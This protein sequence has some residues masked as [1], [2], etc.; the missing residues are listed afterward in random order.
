VETPKPAPVETG[1]TVVQLA[2][3][4]DEHAATVMAQK[5]QIKYQSILGSAHLHPVRADLGAKGI[6]YRIQSQPLS[7]SQAKSVC[8]AL[9]NQ[10]AGCL[11]VRR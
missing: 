8:A 4:P 1:N 9:K 3:L 6:F 11:L 7:D 5:L 10:N 2:A